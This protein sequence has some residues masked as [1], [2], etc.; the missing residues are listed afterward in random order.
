M[1]CKKRCK[2]SKCNS[3]NPCNPCCVGA[4]GLAG[5]TG[6]TGATGATGP[7]DGPTGPAGA[8]GVT[9]A[10]GATG[11]TGLTGLT[12][13]GGVTGATGVTGLTG[14]TGATGLTG[15]TGVDG[16]GAIIPFAANAV[17]LVSG[18]VGADLGFAPA[19]TPVILGVTE[20]GWRVSRDGTITSLAA[21]ISGIIGVLPALTSVDITVLLNGAPTALVLNFTGNGADD[22]AGSVPVVVGDRIQ[23]RASVTGLGVDVDINIEGSIAIA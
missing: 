9:G 13:L 3:C 23:F 15:A 19:S 21:A 12:G 11:V 8:T 4:T 17:P 7:G 16:G 18:I 2:S 10:T 1:S 22:I 5:I 20:L 6:A 14:A